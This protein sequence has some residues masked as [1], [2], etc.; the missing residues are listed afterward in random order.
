M[1][2]SGR[3]TPSPKPSVPPIPRR[4]S[5]RVRVGSDSLHGEK[6]VLGPSKN[7]KLRTR[8]ELHHSSSPE[9]N[10]LKSVDRAGSVK[11]EDWY[12]V[13]PLE[14]RLKS[15]VSR[16]FFSPTQYYQPHSAMQMNSRLPNDPP[17]GAGQSG[18]GQPRRS[19]GNPQY[20]QS[21]STSS[22]NT[23]VG[24]PGV[25]ARGTSPRRGVPIQYSTSHGHPSPPTSF[26]PSD[27]YPANAPTVT[28]PFA[29]PGFPTAPQAAPTSLYFPPFDLAHLSPEQQQ[30][31][32]NA[33]Y[34]ILLL[35][36]QQQQQSIHH[37]HQSSSIH[38]QPQPHS[39]QRM[40][41]PIVNPGSNT[42][43]CTLDNTFLSVLPQD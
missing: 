42:P 43:Q 4:R 21:G 9:I 34:Q 39:L 11:R 30:V 24:D 29:Q 1:T 13:P 33:H 8:D 36:A 10:P 3:S 7:S 14:H 5:T 23:S 25:A 28:G 6:S 35:G 17:P 22:R 26:A 2:I 32:I 38:P 41:P 12:E 37:T 40:L 19:V 15:S 27:T 16:Y 20:T 18:R 31:V